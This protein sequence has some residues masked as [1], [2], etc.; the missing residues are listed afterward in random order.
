MRLTISSLSTISGGET[1][2]GC[3]GLSHLSNNEGG[4]GSI[5]VIKGGVGCCHVRP[6]VGSVK[7]HSRH[8]YGLKFDTRD[9][10]VIRDPARFEGKPFL[11]H[12][13][14]VKLKI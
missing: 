9:L 14:E 10:Q 11:T 12:N 1:D 13:I 2:P 5:Y 7:C 3:H 4:Q 8:C 6:G